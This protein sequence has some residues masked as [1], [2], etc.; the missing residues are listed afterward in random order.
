MQTVVLTVPA[1]HCEGCISTIAQVLRG[2]PGVLS[3]RGDLADKTLTVVYAPE[4][5]T[6]VAMA[7]QMEEMGFPVTST[8]SA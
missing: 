4:S 6:T 7:A 5:V 3:V 1:L 2:F 8:R